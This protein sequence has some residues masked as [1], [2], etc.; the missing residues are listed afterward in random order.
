MGVSFGPDVHGHLAVE[1]APV[2]DEGE[3]IGHLGGRDVLFETIGH[4]G[5]AGGSDRLDIGSEQRK[6]FAIGLTK[7]DRRGGLGGE[8]SGFGLPGLGDDGVG[9]VVVV[10]GAVGLKDVAQ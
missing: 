4:E 9:E 6:G 1:V 8:N 5:E 7:R 3:E 2:A 10:D